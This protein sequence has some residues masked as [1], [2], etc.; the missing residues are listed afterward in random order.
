MAAA[1]SARAGLRRRGLIVLG[2]LVLVGLAAEG[3]ARLRQW[4]RYG[5]F[6]PI[7]SFATHTESG[8]EIPIP[9]SVTESIEIDSRG[10]RSPELEMPK[11]QGRVR[12][13]FL[14]GST[15]YCAEVSSN[16]ATWPALVATGLAEAFPA[17][18]I[19]WANGGVGG[20][21]TQQSLV[22]W[23]HRLAPVAPD[24]AVIYHATNDI[25][26]DTRPLAEAGGIELPAE[27]GTSWFARR[28]LAWNLIEKNVLLQKRMRS[29]S[30]DKLTLGPAVP[31]AGFERRLT[32]LVRA[33]KKDA[34]VV[35]LVTFSTRV[36]EEQSA[37]ERLAA[38]NTSIF[39][40]P[41]LVPDDFVGLFA[42]YNGVIR[43][44]AAQEGALLVEGEHDIPA[45]GEHFR[46]SVHFTDAGCRAQAQRV[47]LALR[48]AQE[49]EALLH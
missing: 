38:C 14:G 44:V 4:T 7:Y 28:S 2:L 41:Y 10:F 46:D 11:P 8:L 25:T 21:S 24:V 36:R 42:A 35:V 23:E 16:A 32:E 49:I 31:A 3:T 18:D 5:T 37:E 6:G 43:R 9:H 1:L 47:L 19:D 20:Y 30:R 34:R 39:Y 29:Q 45:D 22:N 12:F 13:A 26:V 33:C 48:A 40:N 15:T 17:A 27:T